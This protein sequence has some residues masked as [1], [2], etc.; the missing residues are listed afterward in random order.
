MHSLFFITKSVLQRF[1]GSIKGHLGIALNQKVIK[2]AGFKV[3]SFGFILRGFKKFKTFCFQ[4]RISVSVT[5]VHAI[6]LI[7]ILCYFVTYMC[8]TVLHIKWDKHY[9]R[10]NVHV[11]YIFTFNIYMYNISHVGHK[12]IYI[13]VVP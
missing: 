6:I 13:T 1:C 11:L 9:C 8:N 4:V 7:I 2:D 10:C 3:K 12:Y 5:L